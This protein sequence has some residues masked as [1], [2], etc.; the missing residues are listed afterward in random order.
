MFFLAVITA[1]LVGSIPT[2]YLIGTIVYD[3]DVRQKGSRNLGATN[4][5]RVLGTKP[6][7]I[8]LLLD[9]LKGF[10]PVLLM[11][12]TNT[13]LTVALAVAC[14]AGHCFSPWV[15]WKGGKGVATALGALLAI[16]PWQ[17]VWTVLIAVSLI[18]ATG[19]VSVGSLVG[20]I[21]FP[22]FVFVS[23]LPDAYFY[24]AVALG[25]M[26]IVRHGANLERLL[27]GTEKPF[28]GQ[29]KDK[30]NAAA[31]A[32]SC[33]KPSEDEAKD[34]V[35]ETCNTFVCMTMDDVADGIQL[36]SDTEVKPKDDKE[37]AEK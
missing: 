27:A 13:S 19:F 10:L 32:C 4:V 29:C 36:V 31:D 1:F 24:L 18:A 21:L 5:M 9:I 25:V 33:C 17:L 14:V 22:L 37:S 35:D 8:C 23:S 3:I 6:G 12:G 11:A 28:W 34:D 20:A 30:D 15:G 2:G 16:A 7:V 26:L